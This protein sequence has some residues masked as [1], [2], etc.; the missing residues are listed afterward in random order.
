MSPAAQK[1]DICKFME[2][3]YNGEYPDVE[4]IIHM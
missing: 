1:E 4:G 2:H 3:E